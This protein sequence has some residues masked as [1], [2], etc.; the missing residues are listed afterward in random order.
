MR[1]NCAF[2]IAFLVKPTCVCV[3]FVS[4]FREQPTQRLRQI[5]TQAN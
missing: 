4:L 3:R 1:T 5:T 2:P